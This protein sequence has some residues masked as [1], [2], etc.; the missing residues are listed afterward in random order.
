MLNYGTPVQHQQR[1]LPNRSLITPFEVKKKK[2][3]HI[4]DKV[5][6]KNK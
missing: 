4:F 2:T 1:H 6:C 5:L 3:F